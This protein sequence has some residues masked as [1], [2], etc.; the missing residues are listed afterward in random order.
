[1]NPEIWSSGATAER[2]NWDRVRELIS[3]Q[4]ENNSEEKLQL[5]FSYTTRSES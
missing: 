5:K 1:M 4:L 2:D 3:A